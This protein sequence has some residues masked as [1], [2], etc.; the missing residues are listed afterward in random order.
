MTQ[1]LLNEAERTE[2]LLAAGCGVGELS[3][4][5][6]AHMA[7]CVSCSEACARQAALWKALGD[8]TLPQVSSNFNRDLYAKID[9][10]SQ[11]SWVD[12]IASQMRTWLAQPA[13]AVATV[14]VV[15]TAG[16][17]FDHSAGRVGTPAGAVSS[18]EAEQVEKTLEDME[19][20]RQFDLNVDDKEASKSL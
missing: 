6:A 5:Q 7:Q 11:Q 15:L 17:V 3:N 14:A 20:L 19:M 8:W 10:L 13:L 12:R 16:F 4:V 9:L 2:L 1:C 18:T